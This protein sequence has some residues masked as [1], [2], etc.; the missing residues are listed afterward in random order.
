M[1]AQLFALHASRGSVDTAAAGPGGAAARG[2]W[3][4]DAPERRP[5]GQAVGEP[6]GHARRARGASLPACALRAQMAASAQDRR[7]PASRPVE[8]FLRARG[9]GTVARTVP[10]PT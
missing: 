3:G 10:E 9:S 7:C 1:T 5:G 6:S 8:P 2:G 4:L